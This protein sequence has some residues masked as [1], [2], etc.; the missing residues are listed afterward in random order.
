MNE[1]LHAARTA[2]RTAL[3]VRRLAGVN[4]LMPL[5]IYDLAESL[6]VE[7]RFRPEASLNGMYIK[8]PKGLILISSQ[9]PPGRQA[10]TCAHEL[11]HHVFKH[12]T[13]VDE[14]L[15]E[16]DKHQGSS[17]EFIADMFAAYLLMPPSAIS[18]AFKRRGW[19]PASATPEQIYILSTYLGV[20]YETLINHLHR[21]LKSISP[22]RAELLTKTTP[23]RI[24]RDLTGIDVTGNLIV[25]DSAW[26]GRPIDIQVGDIVKAPPNIRLEGASARVT[27]STDSASLITGIRPGISRLELDGPEWSSFLRV[28]RLGYIGRS[29]FRHL[30]DP[31]EE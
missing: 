27:L 4:R 13:R 26:T 17:E 8:G 29:I 9:R 5:C 24:K 16:E 12:G 14:Y 19:H 2:Q 28:S 22:Q 30:E 15:L 6:G 1:R 10:F 18:C 25:A 31:D 3:E 11:G 21:T 7:V 20:G 23:K